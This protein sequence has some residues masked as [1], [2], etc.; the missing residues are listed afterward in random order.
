MTDHAATA[1]MVGE[2]AVDRMIVRQEVGVRARRPLWGSWLTII[3]PHPMLLLKE[4]AREYR[5]RG[6]RL[7]IKKREQRSRTPKRMNI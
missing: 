7:Q 5:R 3:R 2:S 1:E 4:K 6:D